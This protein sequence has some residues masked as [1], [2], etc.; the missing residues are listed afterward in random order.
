LVFELDSPDGEKRGG[1]TVLSGRWA[2][3]SGERRY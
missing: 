1:E 2:E 3:R